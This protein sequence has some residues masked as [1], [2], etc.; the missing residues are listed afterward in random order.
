MQ[1]HFLQ[2]EL[3]RGENHEDTDSVE[4]HRAGDLKSRR[5]VDLILARI[6]WGQTS[7]MCPKKTFR[8]DLV[9]YRDALVSHEITTI[10]ISCSLIMML[11]RKQY[12]LFFRSDK[13][14]QD[15]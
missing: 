13:M 9:I 11:C 4:N 15:N 3:F 2:R 5:Q 14:L 6:F 12:A 7:C 1:D 8:E 10:L